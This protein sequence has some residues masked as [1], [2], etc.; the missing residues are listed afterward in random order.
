M[1]PYS[2]KVSAIFKIQTKGFGSGGRKQLQGKKLYWKDCSESEVKRW[3]YLPHKTTVM[4]TSPG[5]KEYL[6]EILLQV[7]LKEG[8][9]ST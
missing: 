3:T 8:R 5:A 9:V 2:I 7:L 1:N 6:V 4:G